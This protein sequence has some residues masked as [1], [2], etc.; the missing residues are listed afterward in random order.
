VDAVFRQIAQPCFD[1]MLKA[2]EAEELED[3]EEAEEYSLPGVVHWE[4]LEEGWGCK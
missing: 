2:I 1:A 3:R 4:G